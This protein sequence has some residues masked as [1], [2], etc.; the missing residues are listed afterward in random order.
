M[1]GMGNTLSP[2]TL[3]QWLQI[4]GRIFWRSFADQIG[5]IS[6]GVAFYA[7]LAIFPAIAALVAL[8]GLFADPSAV[9]E[10]LD[11]LGEVMPDQAAAILLD[12]AKKVSGASNEGLSLTLTLGVI[13]AIYLSTRATTGL[14]HGLNVAHRCADNRGLV[15]YWSTVIL[16]TVGLMLGAIMMSLLLVGLPTVLAFL[17]LAQ[18]TLQTLAASRWIVVGLV[19][20]SGLSFVFRFGPADAQH[21]W[22][23]FSPGIFLAVVLW[24]AASIGFAIYVDN[25]GRYNETFG[26]LGGVIVLLTWLWLSAFI[27]LMAAIVDAEFNKSSSMHR[28]PTD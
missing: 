5:L 25:F 26:S 7:L 22:V 21:R 9:V 27:V 24:F 2:R 8:A 15:A 10:Q 17:P 11:S 6:A 28:A 16:L 23:W 4:A 13:F 14:I 19:L 20:L 18:D 3:R 12:Q 1:P